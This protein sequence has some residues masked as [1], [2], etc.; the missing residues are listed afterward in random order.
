MATRKSLKGFTDIEVKLLKKS[1]SVK[2][3][4]YWFKV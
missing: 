4:N 1:L 3:K 2:Y